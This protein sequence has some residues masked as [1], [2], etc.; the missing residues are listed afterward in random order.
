[1]GGDE[2][3]DGKHR[4]RVLVGTR[5]TVSIEGDQ[6]PSVP[7]DG[8]LTVNDALTTNFRKDQRK[9]GKLINQGL[10]RR[11]HSFVGPATGDGPPV[12]TTRP[13]GGQKT[14]AF[15]KARY[16]SLEGA[17]ATACLRARPT[18]SLRIIPAS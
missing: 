7:E 14:K 10:T 11:V 2:G 16:R 1:M 6:A 17:G 3:T 9:S 8:M 4:P 12:E 15:A 18:D 13:T 5:P